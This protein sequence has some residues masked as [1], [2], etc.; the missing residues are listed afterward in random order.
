M[1]ALSQSQFKAKFNLFI[2]PVSQFNKFYYN[3][4]YK[5]ESPEYCCF[6]LSVIKILIY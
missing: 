6:H 2:K 5:N 4:P 3:P 1:P